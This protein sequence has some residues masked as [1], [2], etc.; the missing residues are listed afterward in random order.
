LQAVNHA[1]EYVMIQARHGL[2]GNLATEAQED[3]E[4]GETL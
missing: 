4:E 2:F 1:V 3:D